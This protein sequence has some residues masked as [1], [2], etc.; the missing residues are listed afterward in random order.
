MKLSFLENETL[1]KNETFSGNRKRRYMER[2]SFEE[3]HRFITTDWWCKRNRKV[4][5]KPYFKPFPSIK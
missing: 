1:R 2:L 4:P 5:R 3:N